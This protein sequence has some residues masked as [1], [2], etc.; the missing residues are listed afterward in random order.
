MQ[1]CRFASASW[2]GVQVLH[3]PRVGSRVKVLNVVWLGKV[4]RRLV[5]HSALELRIERVLAPS[6]YPWREAKR[7]IVVVARLRWVAFLRAA[8]RVLSPRRVL[9]K[10]L[11][12]GFVLWPVV[13]RVN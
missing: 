8:G 12:K 2:V 5:D 7:N 11:S 3:H 1:H 4:D 10:Y 13:W 6:Q 9:K